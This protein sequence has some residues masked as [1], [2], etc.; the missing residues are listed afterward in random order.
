MKTKIE[1]VTD[2][3][4]PFIGCKHVSPGCDHC[5]AEKMAA[6]ICRMN[7][8]SLYHIVMDIDHKEW[9]GYISAF[10]RFVLEKA[11]SWEKPRRVFICSMG[12]IF[13]NYKNYSESS[14]IVSNIMS[15]AAMLPQHTF[16]V[17]TKRPA[18]MKEYFSQEP[19]KLYSRLRSR[20]AGMN[21]LDLFEKANIS[22]PLKNVWLGVTAE[23]QEMADYR[24]PLLL[25]TPAVVRFVSVEPMLTPVNLTE[26]SRLTG[27]GTKKIN[28]LAG[29]E[30]FADIDT[31]KYDTPVN[32]L[33]WVICGS[34]SGPGRRPMELQWARDIK[35][36][37][38]RHKVPFFFRQIYFANKKVKLPTMDGKVYNQMPDHA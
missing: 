3:W 21:R 36:Q 29:V 4:N 6:R 19:G 28:A 1:Y 26:L 8:N 31:N 16:L 24:I 18:L 12:D 27:T 5:Y 33:D 14:E 15:V 25:S 22:L 32:K 35:D 37:C 13:F 7:K 2:S 30:W 17:L 10:S 20:A 23:N 11:F 34:E 9:N 38:E